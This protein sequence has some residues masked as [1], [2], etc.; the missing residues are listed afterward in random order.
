MK[1]SFTPF[2]ASLLLL[3]FS[4]QLLPL[5]WWH[6]HDHAHAEHEHAPREAPGQQ[7]S[8]LGV[9]HCAICDFQF[10]TTFHF[11]AMA[12]GLSPAPEAGEKVASYTSE[13]HRPRALGYALRAPPTQGS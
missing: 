5:E 7:D 2:S 8:M 12:S 11:S 9:E 4:L 13:L 3:L 1:R 6:H 10:I